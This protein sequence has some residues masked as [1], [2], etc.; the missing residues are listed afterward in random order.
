M[1]LNSLAKVGLLSLVSLATAALL[2]Y[3]TR[4]QMA[5]AGTIPSICGLVGLL[6]ILLALI[7]WSAAKISG[8]SGERSKY[9]LLVGFLLLLQV[10]YFPAAQ[11]VRNQE[12]A[13][14][15]AFIASLIP[16]L[17]A[18]KERQGT[19]P[20]AV[21]AVLTDGAPLPPLLQ[22]Q[23]Q[24]PMGFDNR[25]FYFQRET[26]Y[27]FRFYLPDGFIGSSYEYCCGS[28]GQWTVTD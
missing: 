26:T 1:R 2:A 11:A 23:G 28:R 16:R 19:Y 15:Q 5:I 17:E 10:A 6:L 3:F 20:P 8:K 13:Q 7:T 22:L 9:P 4:W 27:G 21:E 14:T 18:Y 24:L 12:L 25:N